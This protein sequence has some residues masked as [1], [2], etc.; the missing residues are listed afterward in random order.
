MG[1][2]YSPPP[3]PPISFLTLHQNGLDQENE[4]FR[5]FVSTYGT[6]EHAFFYLPWTQFVAMVTYYSEVFTAYPV[7]ITKN[8]QYQRDIVL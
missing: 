8:N 5:L 6:S 7:N 1:D 3:S 4:P 2:H